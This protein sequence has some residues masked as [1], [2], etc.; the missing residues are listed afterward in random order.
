MTDILDGLTEREQKLARGMA[1]AIWGID[2]DA[3]QQIGIE[4]QSERITLPVFSSDLRPTWVEE[5]DVLEISRS[6]MDRW[7]DV[8]FVPVFSM[9]T[10]DFD[11]WLVPWRLK[12]GY[13]AEIDVLVY[14]LENIQ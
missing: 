10:I 14:R 12:A 5:A 2:L 6:K 11:R 4:A 1:A 9:V 8:S 13:S 7:T 3:T